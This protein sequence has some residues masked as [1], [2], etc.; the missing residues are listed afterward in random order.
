MQKGPTFGGRAWGLPRLR[1]RRQ[2]RARGN[3]TPHPRCVRRGCVGML[4]ASQ[5]C[6]V[7]P[8]CMH[9]CGDE[10]YADS[11]ANESHK[12]PPQ[13]PPADQQPPQ[14]LGHATSALSLLR[15][16]PGIKVRSRES[17]S[18]Q[19]HKDSQVQCNRQTAENHPHQGKYKGAASSAKSPLALA[20]ELNPQPLVNVRTDKQIAINPYNRLLLSN[21]MKQTI[22]RPK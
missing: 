15:R 12:P 22:N 16:G 6:A 2:Q 9:K 20:T 1:V 17:N 4:L 5:G 7:L 21:K 11:K 14:Q 19:I 3:R 13:S 10:G 18:R 8:S